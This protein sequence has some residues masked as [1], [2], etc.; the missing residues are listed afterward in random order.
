[1][2]ANLS[3]DASSVNLPPMSQKPSPGNAVSRGRNIPS[4]DVLKSAGYQKHVPDGF[5]ES[6]E[7]EYAKLLFSENTGAIALIDKRTGQVWLSNPDLSK[8]TVIAGDAK[9]VLNAQV[10]F[11]YYDENNRYVIWTATGMPRRMVQSA[12]GLRMG[13]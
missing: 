5:T 7:N 4:K 3:P 8:E 12:Q 10:I 6:L 9:T 2:T 11:K 1:M 13:G